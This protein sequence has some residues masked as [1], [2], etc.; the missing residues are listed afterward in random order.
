[1]GQR[2]RSQWPNFGTW[3]THFLRCISVP[4][5]MSL[6]HIVQERSRSQWSNFDTWHSCCS[7]W[8]QCA[9]FN[10]SRAC[11][12]GNIVQTKF[13][14]YVGQRSRSQRPYFG[15]RHSASPRC[16]YISICGVL[17]VVVQEICSGQDTMAEFRKGQGHS[18]LILVHDTPAVQDVSV[19]QV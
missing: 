1:M 13:F 19:C 17:A 7:R 5:V 9:K 2:S 8:C 18:D 15:T 10:V 11:S 14:Y 4:S 6:G 12:S 16:I 3:H